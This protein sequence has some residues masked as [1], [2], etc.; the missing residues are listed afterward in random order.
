MID[1]SVL[2]AGFAGLF[3]LLVGSFLNVVIYRLPLIMQREWWADVAGM[4][5]DPDSYK[6]IFAGPPPGTTMEEG[7]RLES[8]LN[9]LPKFSLAAPRSR[10]P[11]CGHPIRWWENVPVLSYV[12]LRGKCS[13]CAARISLR[14]PI[15]ELL[16]GA[17]FA[18]IALRWGLTWQAVVWAVFA[19]ILI[20][21]FLIDFDTQLLPDDLNYLL[22]WLGLAA[23]TLGWSA[24]SLPQSVWGAIIG[25]LSLW[26]VYQIHFRITGR[27]GM[28]HG[29]FKL[30]A[31]LGAWFGAK[32]LFALVLLSSVVGTI[33]GIT[34]IVIGRIANRHIPFAFGPFIAGAGLVA[35]ALGPDRVRELM[36]FA[37][38]F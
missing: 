35:F 20:A 30:M 2:E 15:V 23:A 27:P 38:P 26:T 5:T 4:L 6:T 13:A 24:A 36:P 10:C 25:Y 12:L 8:T 21:Q 33:V 11:A 9:A 28:G 3:G 14:Y 29:D 7:Q 19:C 16:C 37:F 31:A 18:G 32:F 34:L 22:L 1:P 17:T